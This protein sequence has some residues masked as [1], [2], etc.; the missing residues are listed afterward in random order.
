CVL[1]PR[2][3]YADSTTFSVSCQNWSDP[4]QQIPL[5]YSAQL[6]SGCG[7]I[8]DNCHLEYTTT[9]TIVPQVTF[10]IGLGGENP[11]NGLIF[12]YDGQCTTWS[13]IAYVAAGDALPH[14]DPASPPA[15]NGHAW[16]GETLSADQGVWVNDPT[17]FS[18]QWYDCARPSYGYEYW[19]RH[20]AVVQ[21]GC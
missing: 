6:W 8:P 17:S 16:I 18:Y 9:P 19:E 13:G 14:N 4:Y 1:V 3:G 10:F 2:V 21:N 12:Q 7:G 15:I 11:V 5:T 20:D